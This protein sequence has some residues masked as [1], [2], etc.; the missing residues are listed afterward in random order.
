MLKITLELLTQVQLL[1]GQRVEFIS[2]ILFTSTPQSAWRGHRVRKRIRYALNYARMSFDEDDLDED[3]DFTEVDLSAFDFNEVRFGITVE[4]IF[5]LHEN[6][7]C[8]D[9]DSILKP[10]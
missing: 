1:F 3:L 7:S 10:T 2:S 9:D 5:K 8:G 4:T 6:E